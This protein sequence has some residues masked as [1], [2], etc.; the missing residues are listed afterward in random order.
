MMLLI[1]LFSTINPAPLRADTL[2]AKR[3]NLNVGAISDK[4]SGFNILINKNYLFIK[5]N[6]S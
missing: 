5:K 4:G 3:K 1:L 2:T 6:N